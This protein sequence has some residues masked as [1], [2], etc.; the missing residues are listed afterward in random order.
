MLRLAAAI[1]YQVSGF[2]RCAVRWRCALASIYPIGHPIGPILLVS[3]DIP[4]ACP[5]GN[6]VLALTAVPDVHA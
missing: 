1:F 2:R 4:V 5:R 6:P 3:Q